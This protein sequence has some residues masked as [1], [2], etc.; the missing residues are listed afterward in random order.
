MPTPEIGLRERTRRAVRTELVDAAMEL[1]LDRGFEAT[2][3]EEIATAAGL[4]RRSYF[5]YFASKDEVFAEGLAAIGQV[6]ADELARRPAGEVPWTALRRSF[7]PL[8]TRVESDDRAADLGRLV[9]ESPALQNSHHRKQASWQASI[10]VALAR[11]LDGAE[12][13]LR[14]RALAGAALACFNVAQESWLAAGDERTLGSLLD[15]AMAEVH[16]LG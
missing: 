12:S 7:D 10:S 2:T 15:A 13:E 16:P 3:V 11:R 9:L 4:S 6:V 1:F 8:I 5:R 14:S